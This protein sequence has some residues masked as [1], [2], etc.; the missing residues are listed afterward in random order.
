MDSKATSS[1]LDKFVSGFNALG[2][3]LF[4]QNR[5]IPVAVHD[6]F[7]NEWQQVLLGIEPPEFGE[8]I[9]EASI[10]DK[11]TEVGVFAE[12]MEG[13]ED[14]KLCLV[15][16]KRYQTSVIMNWNRI[17]NV[18]LKQISLDQLLKTKTKL[19]E[20]VEISNQILITYRRIRQILS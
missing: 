16:E 3:F 17:R 15:Y 12:P 20:M 13:R 6:D 11:M 4:H 10:K 9:R 14:V 2:I 5:F 7:K 18:A 1:I 8:L 19:D